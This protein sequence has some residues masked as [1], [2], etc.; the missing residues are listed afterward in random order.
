MEAGKMLKSEITLNQEVRVRGKGAAIVVDL[1]SQYKHYVKLLFSDG[2]EE[3]ADVQDIKTLPP[4]QQKKPRMFFNPDPVQMYAYMGFAASDPE[5]WLPTST[6]KE[7]YQETWEELEEA[8]KESPKGVTIA[9][10][11]VG[12]AFDMVGTKPPCDVDNLGRALGVKFHPFFSNE[13]SGLVLLHGARKAW[14]FHF[15]RHGF[16]DGRGPRDIQIIRSTVPVEYQ[17]AFDAGAKGEFSL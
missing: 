6:T 12:N 2:K 17:S 11:R 13:K 3:L 8:L 9:E 16:K 1:C 10:K 14:F 5:F 15:L 4:P 7:L